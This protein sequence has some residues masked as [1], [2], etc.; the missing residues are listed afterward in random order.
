MTLLKLFCLLV[1]FYLSTSDALDVEFPSDQIYFNEFRPGLDQ[2][3]ENDLRALDSH[4][5]DGPIYYNGKEYDGLKN[6]VGIP[7]LIDG[8]AEYVPSEFGLWVPLT[9]AKKPYPQQNEISYFLV[10]E[11]FQYQGLEAVKLIKNGAKVELRAHATVSPNSPT[12]I[13]HNVVLQPKP[14]N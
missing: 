13:T 7:Q 14:R 4:F 5:F 9:I 11:V 8:A 2:D 3:V 6:T 10:K 12:H 1:I